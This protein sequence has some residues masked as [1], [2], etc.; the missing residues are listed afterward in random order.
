MIDR[1]Y[2]DA[3]LDILVNGENCEPRGYKTKEILGYKFTLFNSKNCIITNKARNL[4]YAFMVAEWLWMLFGRNDT[5]FI[6]AFNKKILNYSD[7]GKKFYGAYGPEISN[8]LE[9]VYNTLKNDHDSRQ[10]ICT[11]WRK[12]PEKSKDIPCTISHQYLVRDGELHTIASMR[13]ND[14]YLGFP[15]D[16]F[17]FCQMGNLIA[18]MLGVKRGTYTL[19]AGSFHL[20][21]QHIESAKNI[22]TNI[23]TT[24]PETADIEIE[25][26][27]HYLELKK[28]FNYYCH[29]IIDGTLSFEII[30]KFPIGIREHINFL[31]SYKR[32]T[33]RECYFWKDIYEN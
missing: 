15:Y 17:N 20:Y 8:Q 19:F 13:S 2:K 25:D 24:M 9:Y 11:M 5:N 31:N 3:I 7:D 4:N 1:N 18:N 21:E 22:T 23:T 27:D 6:G 16:T 10:A 26:Y 33:H 29:H 12:N 30:K 14:V 32:R 28:L